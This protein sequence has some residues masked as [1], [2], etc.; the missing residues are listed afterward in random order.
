MH[1]PPSTSLPQAALL[2]KLRDNAIASPGSVGIEVRELDWDAEAGVV[3]EGVDL[4]VGAEVAY[5]DD[6]I[7]PLARLIDALGAGET[8]LIGRE[9]RVQLLRLGQRLSEVPG[10]C[11]EER[12]L[13]LVSTDAATDGTGH[14]VTSVHRL[15]LITRAAGEGP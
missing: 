6:A 3:P 2:G 12:R 9:Y 7:E 10:L 1:L 14:C 4:V 13:T 5:S 15:L 8:V 11:V